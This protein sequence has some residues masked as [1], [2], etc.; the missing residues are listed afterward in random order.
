MTLVSL[1][2]VCAKSAPAFAWRAACPSPHRYYIKGAPAVR[3]KEPTAA[4]IGDALLGR[5]QTQADCATAATAW[6]E[7]KRRCWGMQAVCARTTL[8]LHRHLGSPV[9]LDRFLSLVLGAWG[10][11]ADGLHISYEELASEL[12]RS[13]ATV[14]RYRVKGEEGG[15]FGVVPTTDT[16]HDRGTKKRGNARNIYFPGPTLLERLRQPELA[17]AERREAE[18]DAYQRQRGT[19]P[20]PQVQQQDLVPEREAAEPD[21][22]SGQE[23][24]RLFASPAIVDPL[25]GLFELVGESSIESSIDVGKRLPPLDHRREALRQG[26]SWDNEGESWLPPATMPGGLER[27]TDGDVQN[28]FTRRHPS[29]IATTTP[30]I[31]KLTERPDKSAISRVRSDRAE[32]TAA[33]GRDQPPP[34]RLDLDEQAAEVL[35]DLVD[36]A[37]RGD[38]TLDHPLRVMLLQGAAR[39]RRGGEHPQ[40]RT[41]AELV[42]GATQRGSPHGARAAAYRELIRAIDAMPEP[43]ER[44]VGLR[45]RLGHVLKDIKTNGTD[46]EDS[47]S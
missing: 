41:L 38:P 47:A 29:R 42:A 24:E 1:G 32:R 45:S 19:P 25:E 46:D 30:E 43:P 37:S 6:A 16:Y 34:P 23:L 39:T 44:L 21:C 2:D 9:E 27:W 11:G 26:W 20:K 8:P 36:A 33:P 3:P 13:R 10:D 5:R 22:P 28:F 18:L 17:A 31:L 14:W 15:W 4:L 12:D 7:L 40:T 35:A